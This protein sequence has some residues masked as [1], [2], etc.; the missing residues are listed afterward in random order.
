ME[1][2]QWMP[3]SVKNVQVFLKPKLAWISMLTQSI[4]TNNQYYAMLNRAEEFCHP[5]G[6]VCKGADYT[7]HIY[8]PHGFSGFPTALW[9]Q[10]QIFQL[11]MYV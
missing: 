5:S 11:R 3:T 9:F 2:L 6:A 7:H 10:V 1:L 8:Y 4:I